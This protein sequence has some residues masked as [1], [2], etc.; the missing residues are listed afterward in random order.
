VRPNSLALII[1][2]SVNDTSSDTRIA[3]DAVNPN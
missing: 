2:V 1:G 3:T